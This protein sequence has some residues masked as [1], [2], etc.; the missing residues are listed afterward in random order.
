MTGQRLVW[1]HDDVQQARERLY[2]TQHAPIDGRVTD[3]RAWRVRL[4]Q[5]LADLR[6]AERALADAIAQD[7][8]E[9]ELAEQW[10]DE[11]AA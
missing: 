6:A 10:R 3:E 5:R 7:E 11:A 1:L 8:S 9:A 2:W 4:D